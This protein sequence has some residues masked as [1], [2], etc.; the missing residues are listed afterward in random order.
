M[1]VY[2]ARGLHPGAAKPEDDEAIQV[3]FFPLFRAVSMVM[4]GAVRDAK[5]I[6]SILWFSQQLNGSKP[7]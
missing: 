5:T 3:R 2:L 1:N 7:R 6:S 4:N